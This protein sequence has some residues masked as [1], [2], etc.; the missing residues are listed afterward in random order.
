MFLNTNALYFNIKIYESFFMKTSS[1]ILSQF[2]LLHKKLIADNTIQ[3]MTDAG[4]FGSVWPN[5]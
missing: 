1:I 3:N 4:L 2:L 5:T